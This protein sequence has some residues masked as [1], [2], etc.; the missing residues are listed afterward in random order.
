MDNRIVDAF[1]TIQTPERLKRTTK[2][3][4]RKQTFNYGRNVLQRR[5]YH[6][7]LASVAACF[8]LMISCAGLWFLPATSIAV[9]INPSMEL[10]VNALDRVISLKGKN[11]DGV[12]VVETMTD[13]VGMPYDM[14]MNRL[15]MSSG[16]QPYLK[17]KMPITITVAGGGSN[18]HAEKML[19]KVLC[20]TYAVA[21]KEDVLYCQV[22]WETVKAARKVNLCIPR[23]LAWRHLRVTDPTITA[24]DVRK[25][26]REEIHKLAQ[27]IILEN[28][29]GEA[30]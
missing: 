22:D 14:A 30:G 29:C 4:L 15:L 5:Q 24:E 10:K 3:A 26:P 23:Y 8:A 16:L 20:R 21:E 2:A 6:R 18:K 28:P 27:V 25:I 19:S 17:K 12:A 1:D 13:V 11:A 7:R 9:D